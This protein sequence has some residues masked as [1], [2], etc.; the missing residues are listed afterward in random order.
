MWGLNLNIFEPREPCSEDMYDIEVILQ[1]HKIFGPFPESYREIAD[2]TI[3]AV[4]IHLMDSVS[5][6]QMKPF[7]KVGE[8]EIT[9]A[10]KRFICKIMKLDPRDRPTAQQ[11]LEDEWFAETSARTVCWYSREKW[12]KLQA[13]Q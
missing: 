7:I 6:E 5:L 10:D 13:T 4:M 2:E 3:Q 11:L 9:P 12:E 1:Q 8:R